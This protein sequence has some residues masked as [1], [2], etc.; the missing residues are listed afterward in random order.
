MTIMRVHWHE[1]TPCDR[2]FASAAPA[3]VEAQNH[4][5]FVRLAAE[6]LALRG[7][8]HTTRPALGR[9]LQLENRNSSLPSRNH[10]PDR[11]GFNLD[12]HRR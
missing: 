9:N 10:H 1:R 2:G 8:W 12:L 4:A 3:L 11:F 6:C 5:R 7:T